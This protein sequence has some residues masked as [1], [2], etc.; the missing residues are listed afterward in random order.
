[1][2]TIYVSRETNLDFFRVFWGFDFYF[3]GAWNLCFQI[4][5]G[6]YAGGAS[7][8]FLLDICPHIRSPEDRFVTAHL[9]YSGM[10]EM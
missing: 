5:T 3:F 1:M 7:F 9:V 4:I 8:C 6:I 10:T 2:F